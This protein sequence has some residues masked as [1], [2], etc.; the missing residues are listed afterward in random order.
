MGDCLW[1]GKP[2]RYVTNTKVNSAFH[3]SPTCLAWVKVGRIHLCW[4]AGNTVCVILCGRRR[5][6]A[7]WWVSHEEQYT[8]INLFIFAKAPLIRSTGAPQY[9]TNTKQSNKMKFKNT[10]KTRVHRQYNRQQKQK[11][12]CCLLVLLCTFL[13]CLRCSMSYGR[14]LCW[15]TEGRLECRH[16]GSRGGVLL[17]RGG[18]GGERW[19][20][21]AD[22]RRHADDV[23]Y[24]SIDTAVRCQRCFARPWLPAEG[25]A[26]NIFTSAQ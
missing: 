23:T 14:C 13:A 3:P 18:G 17:H 8:N 10:T 9:T 5:S 19:H 16:V 11:R 4:V 21:D 12:R 15:Q 2:S 20:G 22:I 1:T 24:Q 7:L 26:Y 6:V 25:T